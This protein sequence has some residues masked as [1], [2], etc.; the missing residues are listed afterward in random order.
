MLPW[1]LDAGVLTYLAPFLMDAAGL[2]AGGHVL[3]LLPFVSF[4][5]TGFQLTLQNKK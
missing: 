2:G 4:A 3:L 5:F 1:Q